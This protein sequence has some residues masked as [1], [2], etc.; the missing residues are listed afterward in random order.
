MNSSWYVCERITTF[1]N[2]CGGKMRTTIISP[3]GNHKNKYCQKC[4]RVIKK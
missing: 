4:K 1:C 2:Q 3:S